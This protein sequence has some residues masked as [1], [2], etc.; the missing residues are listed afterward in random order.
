MI[1]GDLN[2]DPQTNKPAKTSLD[3]FLATNHLTQHVSE[4]T[5]ITPTRSSILD[6][7][8]TN[9]ANLVTS[10]VVVPPLHTNDHCMVTG[11]LN[12]KVH[13]PRSFKR[14][15]WDY[16]TAN[17]DNYREDLDRIDWDQC[18]ASGDVDEAVEKWTSLFKD[19]T[20][21][22]IPHK[23]VMVRTKDKTSYNGYLLRLCRKQQRDH[24]MQSRTVTNLP[25]RHTG[26]LGTIMCRK[27]STL[28]MNTNKAKWKN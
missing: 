12:L 25:G 4:P 24:S 1:T 22:C 17:F 9:P 3:F 6:L 10:T 26:P 7:I 14:T 19:S 11:T 2:A 23:T 18:F 15:M 8:I 21:R 20:D 28:N 13:R 5:R 16:G 27:C